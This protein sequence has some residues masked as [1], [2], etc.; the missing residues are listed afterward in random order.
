MVA[1]C[2]EQ[3]LNHLA[4][5]RCQPISK[6]GK[7]CI[8]CHEEKNLTDFYYSSSPMYSLNER[9]PVCKEY[10]KTS[11]LADDIKE[12]KATIY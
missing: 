10:N 7:I 2:Q 8:C 1:T 9:I 5:N 4:I 6:K 12:R 3:N 11:V